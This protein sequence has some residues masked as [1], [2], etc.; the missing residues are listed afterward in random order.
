MDLSSTIVAL[1]R[2]REYDAG[3]LAHCFDAMWS[4]CGRPLQLRGKVVLL[5]PNLLSVRQGPLAC[6][7]P[8]FILAAARWFLD[9]GCQVRLGD[10]PA[11]STAE[12]VLDRL[13]IRNELQ[14]L[15]VAIRSFKRV[16][17]VTLPSGVQAGFGA[18]A[19]DCD[20]LV[21]LPRVKAHAQMRVTMAVKNFFGC[22]SGM[23]RPM[24]HMVHGGSG[25]FASLLV[26][27][28]PVLP[29]TVTLVDGI[30]AMHETGPMGGCPFQA[31]VT[32]CSL[33][34]V[35]VDRALL[36]VL[37]IPPEDSPLMRECRSLGL[38]GS[39]L[40]DLDFPLMPPEDLAVEGFVTPA[41]LSPVRFNPLRFVK[42]SMRRMFVR[43]G[44][45]T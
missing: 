27:L 2:C 40:P 41:E 15:G 21:N 8:V 22:I 33:N 10:S 4:G 20:L 11:F 9:Q 34:P 18:A 36:S 14:R 32:A 39:F 17:I 28:L 42:N 35:A 31:G 25:R 1:A 43:L 45:N 24:W 7:D 37:G 13:G 38:P 12:S 30:I 26:E 44:I 23:R 3:T 19:L 29:D 5:K 16:R 6:T